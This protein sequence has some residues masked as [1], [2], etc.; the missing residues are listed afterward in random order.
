MPY[1]SILIP[2]YNRPE[3]IGETVESIL[4]NDFDD[5]EI[6]IS[7]DKSPR[8]EEVVVALQPFLDD[9]RVH[10]YMQPQNLREARNRDFLFNSAC[11]EWLI[12]LGDDDKLYPNALSTLTVAM[13]RYPEADIYAFGY[14]I[15]DEF[16]RMKYS[17]QSPK[18]LRVSIKQLGLVHEVM[19]SDTFPFWM[20]HPATFCSRKQVHRKIR[21]QMD[22]GIGDDFMFM[23]DFLNQGGV[24][25]II[26]DVL[27]FYRKSLS[28]KTCAQANLSTG[29][30]PQ[31]V[32]RAK[33]MKQLLERTD[34]H[35]SVATFAKSRVCVQ[36]LLYDAILWSD[37]SLSDIR[38]KLNLSLETYNEFLAYTKRKPRFLYRTWLSFKRAHFFVSLFGFSGIEEMVKVLFERFISARQHGR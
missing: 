10:L 17:R 9:S 18:A 32:A 23:I 22:V 24:L 8:Q 14:T 28:L 1:Y 15:I 31:L 6:I 20:Y 7:D 33:I 19:I 3:L 25:Q 29:E 4:S 30:L 34:F 5:F 35:P 21:P 11:G 13:D 26:P 16:G 12:V 38:E 27:M 36:R 37:L 2:S